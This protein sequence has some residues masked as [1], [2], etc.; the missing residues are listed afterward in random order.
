MNL[1]R[2]IEGG[3]IGM[4]CHGEL[5]EDKCA[6]TKRTVES[7]EG[8]TPRCAVGDETVDIGVPLLAGLRSWAEVG[9]GNAY[10]QLVAVCSPVGSRLHVGAP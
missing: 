1:R 6:E 8:G 10:F 5:L 9:E 3:N 4:K 7:A 2:E